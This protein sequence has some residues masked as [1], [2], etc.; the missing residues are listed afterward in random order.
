MNSMNA[1][2][3]PKG[4][5]AICQ[6]TCMRSFALLVLMMLVTGCS[7]PQ[8]VSLITIKAPSESL[9]RVDRASD[10]EDIASS[11]IQAEEGA[12]ETGRKILATGREMTI[13]NREIVRGSCWDYSNAVYTRS[14]YPNDRKSRVVVFKG[15]KSKGPYADAKLIKPGDWLYY[16]NHSYNGIE[17]SAIF[18]KWIDFDSRSALM[19]SYGGEKRNEPA[20]YLTYDLSNVYQIIRPSAESGK[21]AYR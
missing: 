16:I 6:E 14:G 19:L 1:I 8:K 20:R 4:I 13:D 12:D 15:T 3:W 5:M 2:I 11:L 17:H 9:A 7:S 10:N 21:V 18:V